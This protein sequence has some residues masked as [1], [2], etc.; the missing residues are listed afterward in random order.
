MIT[1][2]KLQFI[3]I[4]SPFFFFWYYHIESRDLVGKAIVIIARAKDKG[5]RN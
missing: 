5:E 3:E 4:F 1:S 2:W